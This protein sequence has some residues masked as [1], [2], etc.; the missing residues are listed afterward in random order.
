MKGVPTVF[1]NPVR[2]NARSMLALADWQPARCCAIFPSELPTFEYIVRWLRSIFVLFSAPLSIA[3]FSPPSR[4]VRMPPAQGVL[5][6]GRYKQ[7]R[8]F[9]LAGMRAVARRLRD[10]CD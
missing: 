6:A 2:L 10:P 4:K 8:S 9:R 5:A 7:R 3:W 1:Q